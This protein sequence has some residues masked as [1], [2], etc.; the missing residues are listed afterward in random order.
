MSSLFPVLAMLVVT[1]A[2]ITCSALFVPKGPNQ[3]TVRTALMLA[4]A[5]LY[6]MW[7]VTYMAQLHPLIRRRH[8]LQP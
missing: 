8:Q 2:L 7:A 1:A 6:L 5:A 4:F 3:V